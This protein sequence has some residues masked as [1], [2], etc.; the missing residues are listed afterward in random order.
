MENV[1][2]VEILF[3]ALSTVRSNSVG[4]HW[5]SEGEFLSFRRNEMFSAPAQRT[6]PIL[7]L[8]AP[9]DK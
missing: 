7:P 6:L 2:G 3:M 1:Y 5:W 9:M 4:T 8:A